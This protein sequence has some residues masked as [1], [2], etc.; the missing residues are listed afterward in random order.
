M[1]FSLTTKTARNFYKTYENRMSGFRVI[2]LQT[3][4]E[5]PRFICKE[6]F[7]CFH[8]KGYWNNWFLEIH[9]IKIFN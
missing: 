9:V 1:H 8:L 4:R 2:I 3:D 6:I 5:T 7:G